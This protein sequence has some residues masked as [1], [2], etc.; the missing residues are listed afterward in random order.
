MT[1]PPRV[2]VVVPTFRRPEYLRRAIASVVGQTLSSWELLIVDD[3]DP[4]SSARQ[5]TEVIVRE[6]ADDPR[7][8]YLHHER[9]RG[10]GAARNTGIEAANAAF[11]AFL[12]D[13]DEWHP[14]KLEQ[15]LACIEQRSDE[16]ALVYC[17]VRVVRLPSGQ[18]SL[19]PTDGRS[20]GVRELLRRNT[21]G[22]TS[23]VLCR[24]NALREIGGFDEALPARQ[25]QDLFIRLAQRSAFAFVDEVLVTLYV[26]GGS[27][28]ST[29]YD[30]IIHAHEVFYAKY[31]S[32][33]ESDPVTLK[34]LNHQL[35]KQLIAAERFREA[36]SVLLK[37]L[38][39]Q[40][41]DVDVLYRI[42]LTYALPRAIAHPL[43]W[44]RAR[45]RSTPGRV[46][47]QVRDDN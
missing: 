7:L 25:D 19:T 6:F 38:R 22:T 3:N 15:Q 43:R 2:S 41:T 26:H 37:T 4:A 17:R 12:D 30:G 31:R 28:I 23:C 32:L 8:R 20:H 24:T 29:N 21:I 11:T 39:M 33:I 27:S 5:D 40:S 42:A 10:G 34:A 35:G 1:H 13:D 44:A 18:E 16:T 9:N 46:R 36:R 47:S 14:T 45:L